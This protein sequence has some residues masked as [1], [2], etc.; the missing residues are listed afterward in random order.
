MAQ[1]LAKT[2]LA[3]AARYQTLATDVPG[4]QEFF[5]IVVAEHA[6]AIWTARVVSGNDDLL[7]DNPALARGVRYRIPYIAPLNHLQVALLHRWRGGDQAELV[8]RGI[9]L[10]INGV[11]TGL[12]NSG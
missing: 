2:D 7:Y 3:I 9:H 6:R 1:V 10:A 8:Q 4:A 11:A 12:R 5:E